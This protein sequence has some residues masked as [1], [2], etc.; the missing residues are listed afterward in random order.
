MGAT[1]LFPVQ[2]TVLYLKC[3]IWHSF[4]KG[5][6]KERGTQKAIRAKGKKVHSN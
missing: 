3:L 1:G 5:T 4:K 6:R 2:I